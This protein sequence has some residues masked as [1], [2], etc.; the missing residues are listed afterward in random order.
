MI[1]CW[2]INE[3]WTVTGKWNETYYDNGW[4]YK[5]VYSDSSHVIANDYYAIES[6]STDY[7]IQLLTGYLLGNSQFEGGILLRDNYLRYFNNST[8]NYEPGNLENG[9]FIEPSLEYIY[10]VADML[11]SARIRRKI[12][13]EVEDRWKIGKYWDMALTLKVGF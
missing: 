12:N 9:Y 8:N 6:K 13:T 5:K 10:T 7:S 3:Q 11:I 2:P 1:V 4:W